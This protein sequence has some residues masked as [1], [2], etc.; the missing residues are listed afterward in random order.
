MK[1]KN[2][3]VFLPSFEEGILLH[4]ERSVLRA[5]ITIY[6]DY[7]S[8]TLFRQKYPKNYADGKFEGSTTLN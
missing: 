3:V 8:I 6:I 4:I 2:A 7:Y 1:R 5:V